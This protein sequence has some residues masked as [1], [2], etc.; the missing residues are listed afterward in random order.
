VAHF[1]RIDENNL[2]TDVHVINNSD[3]DGGNFPESEPLGQAFQ[4]SLGLE[5]NWLQCS[6]SASFRGAYPGKGWTY[7]AELDEF[8]APPAPEP[9][10]E[11]P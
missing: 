11:T 9:I 7:D 3:I 5:G 6:W 8:I 1:A 2:V 4:A 10:E